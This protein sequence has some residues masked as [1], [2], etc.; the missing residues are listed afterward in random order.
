MARLV[1]AYERALDTDF[2]LLSAAQEDTVGEAET[3]TYAASAPGIV[4]AICGGK[5]AT[6]DVRLERWD[7]APD[8]AGDEWEDADVLPFAALPDRGPL[9]VAGFDPPE[10]DDGLPVD[11]LGRARVEVLAA[12]RHQYAH[13]DDTDLPAERWLLRFWP[14]DAEPDPLAGLPRRV[15]GPY[16]F[17]VRC[18]GWT[19]AWQAW[20]HTGWM[21]LLLGIEAFGA[22]TRALRAQGRPARPDDLVPRLGPYGMQLDRAGPYSWDS[23]VFGHGWATHPT[24]MRPDLGDTLAALA[25]AAGLAAV[26]TF[27]DALECLVRLGLVARVDGPEPGL[28]VPNP[29][30][31]PAWDVVTQAR[32]SGGLLRQAVRYE[33]GTYGMDLDHL[34]RWAPGGVLTTTPRRVAVRLALRA[35]DVVGAVRYVVA[36]GTAEATPDADGIDADTT[37]TLRRRP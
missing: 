26:E 11:G 22:I 4:V 14:D 29:V 9:R 34:L 3:Q 31:R 23:D 16:P 6:L 13:W 7:G 30:P 33:F 32:G 8:P 27:A 17:E 10:D 35:E 37:V 20:E 5:F 19:A 21:T 24:A 28:L 2:A 18:D 15:A 36:H 25:A 1:A 12:G